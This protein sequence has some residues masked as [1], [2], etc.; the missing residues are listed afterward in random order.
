M[1]EKDREILD[2]RFEII[3]LEEINKGL[4]AKVKELCARI[5]ELEAENAELVRKL[6]DDNSIP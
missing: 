5:A 3:K 4:H 2:L 1:C 6:C